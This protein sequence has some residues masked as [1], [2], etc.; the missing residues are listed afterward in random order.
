VVTTTCDRCHVEEDL[1]MPPRY[2]DGDRLVLPDGWLHVSGVTTVRVEFVVD[3]CGD[4]APRVLA[5]A[6]AAPPR[7]SA[8]TDIG[9][10][11]A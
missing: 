2:L 5:A 6:G 7:R 11:W 3:L 10:L 8:T 9:D 4:C 1:P